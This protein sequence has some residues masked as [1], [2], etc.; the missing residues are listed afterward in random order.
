MQM[1]EGKDVKMSSIKVN[2][3]ASKA[4]DGRSTTS[5]IVIKRNLKVLS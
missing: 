5:R 3:T 1:L 4:G 2:V